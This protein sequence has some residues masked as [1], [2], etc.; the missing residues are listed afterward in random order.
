MLLADNEFG[1]VFL[2]F[3]IIAIVVGSA[4][5]IASAQQHQRQQTLERIAQRFRGRLIPGDFLSFSQVRLRFQDYPALLKFTK[6]GKNNYHT[7]FTIT[8][9]DSHLRCEV[10]PQDILSGFRRLWGMEDI[11]I[12]SPHFDQSF[13]I[14]GNSREQVRELLTGQVQAIIFGLTHISGANFFGSHGIQVKWAGGAMTVTKVGYLS[15]YEDL[16]RFIS[17]SAELFIAAMNTRATGITFVEAP[18]GVAE[19]DAEES[20]CQVCGEPLSSDLV[21]CS[22]CKTPHHRECWEYFGGCSTYACG[23]KQYVTKSRRKKA[24]K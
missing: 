15:A 4:L 1:V 17:L 16:E 22:G 21:F 5:A 11:E 24:A 2:F 7:H 9:P 13:F 6:V 3:V 19:P 10:Y 18:A 14:A 8:W 20:Q 23:Q 12:G